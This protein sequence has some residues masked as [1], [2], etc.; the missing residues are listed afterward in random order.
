MLGPVGWYSVLS[1]KPEVVNFSKWLT[2][3]TS[4]EE[5]KSEWKILRLLQGRGDVS[6]QD[7]LVTLATSPEMCVP[8]FSAAIYRLL[9]LPVERG[10][11]VFNDE[12]YSE[13]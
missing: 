2:S 12:S 3:C 7:A 6:T 11:I 5:L 13:Q 1:E 10:T 4:L 9:L 8:V